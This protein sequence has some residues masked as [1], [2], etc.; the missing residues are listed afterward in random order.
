MVCLV[1]MCI[2]Y[3]I[4]LGW[5]SLGNPNW[6]F[7]TVQNYIKKSERWTPPQLIPQN[8]FHANDDPADHGTGGSVNT[9]SYTFYTDIVVPF[10]DA[11]NS[12]GIPTNNAAV[13]SFLLVLRE[14][15]I[16][17]SSKMGI[18][19]VY[20]PSQAPSMPITEAEV[21]AQLSV[22]FIPPLSA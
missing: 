8:I 21:I 1:S 9:T 11:F 14:L 19:S 13:L 15:L 3:L 10:F 5:G 16:T 20:G 2:L 6:T 17:P 12:L 22:S 4:L 7:E 18:L